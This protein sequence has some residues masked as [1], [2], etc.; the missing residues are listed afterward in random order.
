MTKIKVEMVI[1]YFNNIYNEEEI[2]R[3]RIERVEMMKD[4]KNERMRE[5]EREREISFLLGMLLTWG[6]R[7]LL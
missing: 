4:S 1:Y 7:S 6:V 5:K 3:K 2:T